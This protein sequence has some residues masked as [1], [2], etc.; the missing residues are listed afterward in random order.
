L[1]VKRDRDE[2]E[3]LKN[4]TRKRWAVILG[5]IY[6]VFYYRTHDEAYDV[7]AEAFRVTFGTPDDREVGEIYRLWKNEWRLVE[8]YYDIGGK[9]APNP[10]VNDPKLSWEQRQPLIEPTRAK[11]STFTF[12]GSWM[13]YGNI[14]RKEL[15][16]V[17]NNFGEA[18]KQAHTA[19]RRILRARRL[20]ENAYQLTYVGASRSA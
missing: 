3:T 5:K 2:F 9:P 8:M 12:I 16:F 11:E 19:M 18:S 6:N 17:A 15:V 7:I 10:S 13:Q 4:G 14:R 1:A 20:P